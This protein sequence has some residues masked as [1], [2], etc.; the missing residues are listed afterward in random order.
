MES[1]SLGTLN[2]GAG[3]SGWGGNW[4]AVGSFNPSQFSVV[5]STAYDGT[6]STICDGG[7]G[8]AIGRAL[9]TAI[10]G[11]AVLYI[12][13]RRTT[14][15][16][17]NEGQFTLR[18][19]SDQQRVGVFFNTSGRIILGSGGGSV[20]VAAYSA[21]TWYAIRLTFNPATNAATLAFSTSAYGSAGTFGSESSSF[22]MGSSGD[23]AWLVL[24]GGDD[25]TMLFD[26]ISGTSPFTGAAAGSR[27][28][29]ALSLLGVG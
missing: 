6:Q 14:T 13:M 19:T 16:G 3:G 5:N 1:Y 7:T 27:D 26:Y 24:N 25:D 12:A 29:R 18:N 4:G 2:A 28:G 20:D 15:A 22:T 9:T 21:N 8:A 10:S 17:T 11:S 23:V